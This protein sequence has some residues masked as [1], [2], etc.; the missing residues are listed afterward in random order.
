MEEAS[1]SS[2]R[3]TVGCHIFFVDVSRSPEVGNRRIQR[4]TRMVTEGRARLFGRSV[5]QLMCLRFLLTMTGCRG[6]WEGSIDV[7]TRRANHL[8]GGQR[9]R[10]PTRRPE[11]V[12]AGRI[13]KPMTC[14]KVESDPSAGR[15]LAVL[16]GPLRRRRCQARSLARVSGMPRGCGDERWFWRLP[17]VS[18]L[19]P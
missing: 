13:E 2:R 12:P 14:W 15:H 4:M 16:H 11:P 9:Q 7:G 8:R 19:L 18:F 1:S 17:G 3:L 5:S 6:V 10:R